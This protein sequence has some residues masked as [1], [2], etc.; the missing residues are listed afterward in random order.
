MTEVIKLLADV[1]FALVK[2]WIEAV[3]TGDMVGAARA[4]KIIAETIAAKEAI[5]RARRR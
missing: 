5:R 2:P 3:R 4:S 1:G